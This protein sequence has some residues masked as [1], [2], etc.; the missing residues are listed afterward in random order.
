[1]SETNSAPSP[2][3]AKERDRLEKLINAQARAAVAEAVQLDALAS[4]PSL[5]LVA[6]AGTTGTD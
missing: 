6:N 3:T 4:T 1:M 5:K 2:M